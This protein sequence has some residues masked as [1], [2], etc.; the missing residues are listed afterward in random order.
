MTTRSNQPN[1]K[2]VSEFF[3]IGNVNKTIT[4]LRE[5]NIKSNIFIA[6]YS[7][8]G[9]FS[10]IDQGA[11]TTKYKDK[12]RFK[13]NNTKGLSELNTIN[14]SNNQNTFENT[15]SNKKGDLSRNLEDTNNIIK[16]K[17]NDTL[18]SFFNNTELKTQAELGFMKYTLNKR[19]NQAKKNEHKEIDNI[20]KK[21]FDK[22]YE[23]QMKPK[24]VLDAE[25]KYLVSKTKST[26]KKE[27]EKK[28]NTLED[29][30]VKKHKYIFDKIIAINSKIFFMKSIYD[31]TYPQ[32]VIKRLKE[33]DLMFRRKNL[34]IKL[35][36]L[37]K[38]KK[39]RDKGKFK[40]D[41][42][43]EVMDKFNIKDVN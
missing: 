35:A 16:T 33:E 40:I 37:A 5:D 30:F 8:K 29:E 42:L 39:L 14:I 13:W 21:V 6:T 34:K 12:E 24:I 25:S 43:L 27:K 22:R 36:S 1:I 38:D 41:E 11:L 32:V 19:I 10:T 9:G 3:N 28:Q 20:Y 26:K 7:D 2:N 31:Y 15:I 23:Y 17:Y 18:F 4:K